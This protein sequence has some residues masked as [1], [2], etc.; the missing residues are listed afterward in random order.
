MARRGKLCPSAAK[1]WG[2]LMVSKFLGIQTVISGE[3]RFRR[4]VC[5]VILGLMRLKCLSVI[6][7]LPNGASH[8]DRCLLESYNRIERYNARRL[9]S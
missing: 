5:G 9:F 1:Y 3:T 6:G 8:M 7:L 4:M 2:A